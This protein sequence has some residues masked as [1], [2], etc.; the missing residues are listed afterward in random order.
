MT[1]RRIDTR[2]I[3]RFVLAALVAVF[4]LGMTLH[5][6]TENSPAEQTPLVSALSEHDLAQFTPIAMPDAL[7]RVA[8]ASRS[9]SGE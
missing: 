3:A 7:G 8:G 4:A 6:G 9:H 5:G 2:S 1:M